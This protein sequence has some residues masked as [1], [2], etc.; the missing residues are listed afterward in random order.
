MKRPAG[1]ADVA[2]LAGFVAAHPGIEFLDVYY[3]NLAGVPRGK[4]LRAHEFLSAFEQGRYLPGSLLVADI[5]GLDV[6]E[7][8]MVWEDGDADRVGWPVAGTLKPATWLGDDSAEVMLSMFELSGAP[9]DLDPRRVLMNVIERF[10]ADGLVPVVACELEFYLVDARRGRDGGI[11]LARTSEGR[12]PLHRQVYGLDSVDLDGD[13]LRDLWAA[14]D[15]LGL[16]TGAAIGEYA[17][18]QYE[19]TLAHKPD[20]LGAADDAVRFKRAAKGVADRHRRTAT[21]M[22]KPFAELSGSGL[23]VHVSVNDKKGRNIFA[24]AD[25]AGSAALGF[26][27]GGAANLMPGSIAVFAP[28][29]NSYRRFR[30]NSYAPVRAGW[31]VNNRTVPLRIPAGPPASRHLEHRLSGAD[32]NPYLAVAAVLAGVHH[33]LTHEIDPGPPVT[34]DGE[35]TGE[36]LPTDWSHALALFEGSRVLADY[37]GGRAAEMFATV[38]RVEQERYNAVI[39]PLDFDWVLRSA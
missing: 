26:A 36:R 10:T 32:A 18:G 27:I 7:S 29:A 9:C 38:K 35:T 37:W 34:G 6:E 13:Y 19:M 11:R 15:A 30:P 33:G 21:F 31:G 5:T 12:A 24:S 14:C 20:A 3:T 1:A 23:H 17:P 39:T 4:R 25:P 8:G 16:P 28:N 22:A 2:E